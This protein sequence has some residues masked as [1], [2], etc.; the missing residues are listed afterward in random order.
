MKEKDKTFKKGN[1]LACHKVMSCS[2][3]FVFFVSA[4]IMWITD[5]QGVF[6]N[7]IHKHD[8]SKLEPYREGSEMGWSRDHSPA[9]Y[10]PSGIVDRLLAKKWDSYVFVSFNYYLV[11]VTLVDLTYA[12]QIIITYSSFKKTE[13][14]LSENFASFSLE[15]DF[16]AGDDIRI[17]NGKL[18][19]N[20]TRKETETEQITWIEF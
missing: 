18:K 5:P 15:N 2:I 3:I 4:Y 9:T 16:W 11:E 1:G 14:I 10:K 13:Q 6:L 8:C 19:F 7:Q 17:N 12:S 20:L